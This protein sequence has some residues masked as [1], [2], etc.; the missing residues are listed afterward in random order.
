MRGYSRTR[1]ECLATC[2]LPKSIYADMFNVLPNIRIREGLN[3][4]PIN[5]LP[6]KWQQK[7]I[8]AYF[9]Y[10][11]TLNTSLYAILSHGMPVQEVKDRTHNRYRHRS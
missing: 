9:L 4:G 1:S 10:Y 7:L 6:S 2:S 5:R 3:K 11:M 8:L